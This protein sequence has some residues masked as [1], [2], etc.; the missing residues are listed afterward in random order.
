L[1]DELPSL[2]AQA[3]KKTLAAQ[4]AEWS[5]AAAAKW[6]WRGAV[7]YRRLADYADS[8]ARESVAWFDHRAPG[9]RTTATTRRALDARLRQF[10]AQQDPHA[11]ILAAERER[12]SEHWLN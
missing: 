6:G 10:L 2:R 11:R 1:L 3:K 9:Y 5:E 4:I 7:H 12:V 8:K